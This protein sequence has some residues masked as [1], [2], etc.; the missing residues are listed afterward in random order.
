MLRRAL[1]HHLAVVHHGQLVG[2]YP[3]HAQVVAD[4]KIS[5]PVALL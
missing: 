3:D 1:F 2:Q 4:E 5:Q